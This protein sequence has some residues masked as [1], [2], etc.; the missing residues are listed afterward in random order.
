MISILKS[1]C[2]LQEKMSNSEPHVAYTP[3]VP[4]DQNSGFQYNGF[5][6][7]EP[8]YFGR[9]TLSSQVSRHFP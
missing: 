8:N 9:V 6:P 2:K 5:H 7:G 4:P 3:L 1:N